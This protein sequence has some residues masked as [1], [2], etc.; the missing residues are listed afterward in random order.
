MAKKRKTRQQKIVS[1]H[2][3]KESFLKSP[4]LSSSV[5]PLVTP[6]KAVLPMAEKVVAPA[7]SQQ[8]ISVRHDLI[9]T[10]SITGAIVIVQLMLFFWLR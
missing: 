3:Q 4:S 2:R 10:L 5:P 8:D 7:L 9:R 6:A 1:D